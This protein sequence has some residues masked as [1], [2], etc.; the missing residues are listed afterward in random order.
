MVVSCVIVVTAESCEQKSIITI[1]QALPKVTV[2]ADCC[3]T[4][5]L[6]EDKESD[7]KS[8]RV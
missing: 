1:G 2:R 5:P 3:V 4:Q 7:G 6:F 8:G